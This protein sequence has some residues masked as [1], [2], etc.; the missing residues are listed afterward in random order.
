MFN[1]MDAFPQK[2]FTR[3]VHLWNRHDLAKYLIKMSEG[4]C[5]NNWQLQEIL[6]Q[7]IIVRLAH[8]YNNSQRLFASLS[9][10][11]HMFSVYVSDEIFDCNRFVLMET[12]VLS[13]HVLWRN[14]FTTGFV[15]TTKV[16]AWTP[17]KKRNQFHKGDS[18]VIL[19]SRYCMN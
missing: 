13:F 6:Y 16:H 19:G 11:S 1:Q 5:E 18:I 4:Q 17:T 10:I 12:I 7:L 14:M 2:N 15:K 8:F 9:N 3:W